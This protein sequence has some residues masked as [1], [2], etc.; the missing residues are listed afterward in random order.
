MFKITVVGTGYVGLVSGTIFA[1]KGNKVICLDVDQKK[2]GALLDGKIPIYEDGLEEI[3][4]KNIHDGRLDF[5]TDTQRAIQTSD[6]IF[7]AVGTPSLED[8]SADLRYIQA[9]C[10]DIAQHMESHKIVVTKSTVPVGTANKVRHWIEE[11]QPIPIPFDVVSCPEFLREGS[12]VKDSL[13]PDRIVIGG[14]NQEALKVLRELHEPFNAPIIETDSS[15]AEMIKY[16]SN[17]FLATKISFINEISNICEKVDADVAM[18]AQGIGLDKRIGPHFLKAG[19][20]FGGSCF[21]KDTKALIQIAGYLNHDFELLKSVVRVN[22]EQRLK[23]VDKLGQQLG[24]LAG[25]T[26]GILGLAFKPNTDD[27]REAPS[28]DVIHKLMELGCQVKAYDPVA[29]TMARKLLPSE[30]RYCQNVQEVMEGIDAVVILT[31]WDEFKKI[32]WQLI[33]SVMKQPVI[34]DG[35]NMFDPSYMAQKGFHYS[36]FGRK[37]VQVMAEETVNG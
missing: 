9:V 36:S 37:S 2:I 12:A 16:A 25:R 28:I 17:A 35:R 19:A 15:S 18:V 1:E 21:P 26:I 14:S 13:N 31:E 3:V 23:I 30:V 33:K 20:G 11:K 8:G 29:M 34:V 7:I 10:T 32:D 6:I 27:M 24:Q 4:K 5:T 22:S